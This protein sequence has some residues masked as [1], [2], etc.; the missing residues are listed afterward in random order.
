MARLSH[1]VGQKPSLPTDCSQTTSLIAHALR[2]RWVDATR[3]GASLLP[4]APAIIV[5]SAYGLYR[6]PRKSTDLAMQPHATG[7]TLLSTFCVPAT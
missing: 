2:L 4:L 1:A 7:C 5:G 6:A 3:N